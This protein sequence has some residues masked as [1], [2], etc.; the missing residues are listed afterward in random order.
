MTRY[1]LVLAIAMLLAWLGPIALSGP[2]DLDAIQSVADEVH[3]LT[4]AK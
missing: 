2:S 4:E 1:L 3:E